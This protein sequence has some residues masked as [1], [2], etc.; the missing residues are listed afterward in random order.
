MT[1]RAVCLDTSLIIKALV[2]EEPIVDSE[3]ARTTLREAF[4][5][6]LVLAPSFAWAE[7]GSVLRKKVR[8]SLLSAELATETWSEYRSLPFQFIDDALVRERAWQISSEFQFATLY[9]ACFM[10]CCEVSAERLRAP[11]NLLTFDRVLLDQ[12]RGTRCDYVKDFR[13]LP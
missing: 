7:V 1:E 2:D 12:L 10:A 5:T 6:G 11:V 8:Q 9:D 13:G 3:L 4:S